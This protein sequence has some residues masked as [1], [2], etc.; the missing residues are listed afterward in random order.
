MSPSSNPSVE[1]LTDRT[2]DPFNADGD[3]HSLKRCVSP[4][5]S[6][7]GCYVRSR[8]TSYLDDGGEM[9][10]QLLNFSVLGDAFNKDA[11]AEAPPPY[12]ATPPRTRRRRRYE[13]DSVS[14]ITTRTTVSTFRAVR[15]RDA[16]PPMLRQSEKGKKFSSSMS[17]LLAMGGAGGDLQTLREESE[18][19]KKEKDHRGWKGGRRL[20]ERFSLLFSGRKES[21]GILDR[22]FVV[23]G[24]GVGEGLEGEGE[25]GHSSKNKKKNLSI[26]AFLKK[27]E[28]ASEGKGTTSSSSEEAIPL[29]TIDSSPARS[30]KASSSS[31][32]R[33]RGSK[34]RR[35]GV[36]ADVEMRGGGVRHS[37]SFS[38]FRGSVINSANIPDVPPVPRNE[39]VKEEEQDDED[40]DIDEITR[41]A[42]RVNDSVRRTYSYEEETVGEEEEE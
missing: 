13:L 42:A 4:T 5:S 16:C 8:P 14:I 10:N 7:R 24:G 26:S 3:D 20:K 37:K 1:T 27:A 11:E 29:S 21:A 34:M 6:I 23:P 33:R 38:G 35:V 40:E 25:K 41:E 19:H 22:D 32:F 18:K 9:Q 17:N 31:V 12:S 30:R 28:S 15:N 2:F 39:K 36:G